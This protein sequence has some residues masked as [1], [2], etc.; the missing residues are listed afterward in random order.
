M[1]QF[2]KLDGAGEW[3]CPEL[4]H[5]RKYAWSISDLKSGQQI[6]SMHATLGVKDRVKYAQLLVDLHKGFIAPSEK[7][8]SRIWTATGHQTIRR[9]DQKIFTVYGGRRS[10]EDIMKILW[11]VIDLMNRQEDSKLCANIILGKPIIARTKPVPAGDEVKAVQYKGDPSV[12]QYIL[13]ETM[14]GKQVHLIGDF[15]LSVGDW[16]IGE[17]T[18]SFALT[19]GEFEEKYELIKTQ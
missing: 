6:I 10:R 4:A 1:A 3:V 9:G 19:E 11:Y 2:N 12:H 5:G 16:V 8:V 7:P 15:T 18:D 14:Y 13:S 17:G